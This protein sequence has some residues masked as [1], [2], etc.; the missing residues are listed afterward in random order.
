[1]LSKF[2]K[3]IVQIL[4]VLILLVLCFF[5]FKK[6][7]LNPNYEVGQ[8][9][10]SLN[11]VSVYYNGG[12]GNVDGRELTKDGYNL[13]LKYQCVEF[14]KRYYYDALKHK[15]PDSYG[16]A[17]D[18]FN[19]LVKDGELNT[20]R[21]LNQFINP[22]SAKPRVNDLLVYSGTLLNKYGHVAIISKVTDNG[23][24]I[25]QQNPGPFGDSRENYILVNED[26]KWRITNDRIIGWLRK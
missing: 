3:R 16:H 17:K 1:M 5:V 24:E 23:I 18:F 22:S 6:I 21:N 7:N 25:I 2:K 12:V 14:V 4:G 19:P 26:G 11:G 9:I 8:E 13:G 20:Q 15:M 10:D